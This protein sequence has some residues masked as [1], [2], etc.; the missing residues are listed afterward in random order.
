MSDP[1]GNAVF[2][3]GVVGTAADLIGFPSTGGGE[4]PVMD[5]IGDWLSA[6]GVRVGRAEVDRDRLRAHPFFSA[7]V[8]R[9]VAPVLVA[10][11]G[12]GEG[13]TV[14]LNAH[15]DVVPAAGQEGWTSDPFTPVIRDGRLI[16]RGAADTKGGLAA[17]MHVMAALAEDPPAGE[18]LLTPVVGE[19]DGGA[20]TLATLIHGVAV[21]AAVVI[22]PTDLTVAR[23]SAGALCFKVTVPGRTAHGSVRH[24]GVSAIEKG[25]LIHRAL[26]ELE[27]SR[28]TRR[29][30][31]YDADVPFPLCMGRIEGGDYR[32]DEA[33]WLVLE[34]RFGTPPDEPVADARDALEAAVA[35]VAQSDP[36]LRDHP[37]VVEWIG[38]QWVGGDTPADARVVTE[39]E[40]A[41][42]T[43]A[44]GVPYG[45][46]LGLLRQV[47]DIPG[48]V[49]GP[50][51]ADVAH[52]PNESV[53]VSDL[54]RFTDALLTLT[55]RLST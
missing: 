26:L 2:G 9:T 43:A 22:E 3:S 5:W 36:W 17:A 40:A 1:L 30:P 28:A 8:D 10:R 47:C 24:T 20:G 13:P 41:F 39:A 52:A 14:L 33:A 27:A 12:R 35:E 34:G 15:V 32:C 37:P 18:V 25:W 53:A 19:E 7:E 45:C 23:A 48:V 16:G 42:G 49:V 11:V 51:S 29:H 46:D 4:G 31:L 54:A 38:A 55:R 6:R 21:D 50:G 44:V